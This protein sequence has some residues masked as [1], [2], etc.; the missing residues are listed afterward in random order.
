MSDFTH[1]HVHTHYS[2]LDGAANIKN[3]LKKASDTGMTALAITDHGNMYGVMEFFLKAKDFGIKP[4]LGCEVYVAEGSRFDKTNKYDRGHHLILL[5]KNLKGY[6]NLSKLVSLGFLDGFYYN[7]RI[8]K[9]I[10]KQYSEGLIASS[11][12]LGGELP[13]VALNKG[14]EAAEKVIEEFV[15]IFGDD[16]YIELQRHGHAEQDEVNPV[17]VEMAEKYGVKYIA[18]NDIHYINKDDYDAH[19]ILICL[20]TGKDLDD[21]KGLHYSGNE[22][23]KTAEEMSE[24]FADLP[25]ALANT[26]EIVD[27]IED[28]KI[29]EDVILPVFPLPDGFENEDN[30]LS[31]LTREG[32]KNRYKE[33]TEEIDTRIDYELQVIRD[34]GYAGYFLI[35]HDFIDAARKMGV[36]VGPGRGSA[37]GSI[38]A[39]CT[40]ITDIDPIRF[41]LLFERFLNKDRVSMPDIDVDF[42]DEGRDQVIRYVTDKYGSEKVAQI[43]TFGTMAARLAIRDVARVLKLPLPEADRLAKL[44]PEGQI[45]L[46]KAYKDVPELYQALNGSDE[47]IRRTLTFAKTLEGSAR[48]T[49]THACGVIIGRQDLIDYVPLA[50]SKENN[51][52]TGVIQQ[53]QYEGP[54]A[55]KAGLLKMDFLG[56]KTL[57]IIKDSLVTIKSRH[58]IQID[59]DNLPEE[60]T[61]T[62]ELFQR[63]DTGSIFQFESDGMRKY[64]KDLKPNNIED[65]IAMNALYRPGPIDYIDTFINR[66]HGKENVRFP[67]PSI[68]PI[69]Q[70]TYGIMVYQEQIMEIAR[71][72]GGFTLGQA[73]LLRR[74]MGKKIP[75][76]ME[77]KRKDFLEGALNK[78]IEE[79][80]AIEV[81]NTMME[82]ANYGFNR[83][84][85]AAYAVLAYRTAYLK[86]HFPAE[87]MAA[88]LTHN[89][90]DIKKITL[91]I[92]DCR[93]QGIDVLGP[94]VN[95]SE[96]KFTV[97]AQGKIRFAMAAIKGVGEGA[98]ESIIYERSLGGSFSH[99]FDFV[100]RINLRQVNKRCLESL[101]LAG[102]FDEFP[103]SHRAQYFFKEPND[104]TIF[105]ERL[106]KYANQYQN[107]LASSQQSL[108]G[109]HTTASLADPV[110]PECPRWLPLEMLHKEKEVVGFYV[111]GH[112]LDQYRIEIAKFVNAKLGQLRDNLPRYNNSNPVVA[113]IISAVTVKRTKEGKEYANFVLEDYSDGYNFTVFSETYLKYK[114]LLVVGHL[115]LV[116]LNVTTRYKQDDQFEARISHVELLEE[117]LV[118]HVKKVAL[119]IPFTSI[120]DG[121]TK[122]MAA[123]VKEHRGQCPIE[124]NVFNPENND[125]VPLSSSKVKIAPDTFLKQIERIPFVK[126]RISV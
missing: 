106:I 105:L 95:E 125:Y 113:G 89:L 86:A 78:G 17:L 112:P 63:G 38:V 4:I 53:T 126:Y 45:T 44:V 99:I 33:L 87:F 22:Y 61:K 108:F 101:A 36:M 102:A 30:Y 1:L 100:K 7:P 120:S 123:M 50:V 67:H 121:F 110:L 21:E 77:S 96:L 52:G 14:K 42:D 82:F 103:N 74:A 3:L 46:E 114:H 27:K 64:L 55:E 92:D 90:S 68:E 75:A 40:G 124:F 47:L 81:F 34:I 31:H 94:D 62:W 79:K 73:D 69:L 83:S 116:K 98:V 104:E 25:L 70:N 37:A 91:L 72:M 20:N 48:H 11:A 109:D 71:V 32:A 9:E 119:Y 107:S 115:L 57:S 23:L 66:K 12:C 122:S 97:N 111:S 2:I 24:L 8:D 39:Y 19:K 5:A 18:T 93:R 28:F 41:N 10:L 49:G 54:M 15:S 58:G 60:D 43:V 76:E 29:T 118:K 26:R 16:Y 88:N 59:I 13:S 56:L 85:A 6:F 80:T 35:V 51:T 65:L 117:V 84:H